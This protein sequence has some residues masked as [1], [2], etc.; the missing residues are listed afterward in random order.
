MNKQNIP[1]T[2]STKYLEVVVDQKLTKLTKHVGIVVNKTKQARSRL[3]CLIAR[4]S[5][6]MRFI[7]SV[8]IPI[9]M[10]AAMVWGYTCRS[11]RRKIKTQQNISR[12]WAAN[13]YRHRRNDVFRRDLESKRF[14]DLIH[15]KTINSIEKLRIHPNRE[16]RELVE[17]ERADYWRHAGLRKVQWMTESDRTN[18]RC[19]N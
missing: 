13:A 2:E 7:Q 11:N 1:W 5:K 8:I 12:R 16:L 19:K 17:Y 14:L 6:Q 3:N 18:G 9:L 4:K 15:E 10:Y